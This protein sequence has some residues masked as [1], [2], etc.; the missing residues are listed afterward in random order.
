[1]N[2][3]SAT[4][5]YVE[6]RTKQGRFRGRTPFGQTSTL[7]EFAEVVGESIDVAKLT[8]THVLKWLEGQKVALSTLST[9]FS[10]VRAFCHWLLIEGYVA[11]DPCRSIDPPKKPQGV[12]RRLQA[13]QVEKLFANLPDA[14]AELIC[15]LMIQ[16]GLRCAEVAALEIAHVDFEE[17]VM[18]VS[19]KGQKQRLV[20]VSEETMR[21]IRK[22]LAAFPATT[23]PLLRSTVD[24]Y[25]GIS[26]GYVSRMVGRWM[27]DAGI[28]AHRYDGTAA[29]ALRHTAA[30]DMIKAGANVRAV[31]VIL[32]HSS[33]ATTSRYLGWD[34]S[35]LRK[36]AGGRTYRA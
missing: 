33:L 26:A 22:Y 7:L 25:K 29:H 20:P 12:P 34:I 11:S 19:G 8:R 35:D 16:E 15:T 31:Q 5:R 24:T 1:M 3:Q 32:G 18:V 17:G 36:A 13:E 9:K 27:Q 28:K 30:T 14:R 4:L 23:G 21:S 10:Q 2:L 6:A